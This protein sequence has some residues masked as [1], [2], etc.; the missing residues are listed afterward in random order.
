M[1]LK[2][3]TRDGVE[4]NVRYSLPYYCGSEGLLTVEWRSTGAS[5][6]IPRIDRKRYGPLQIVMQ[7]ST[8]DRRSTTDTS[9]GA[10]MQGRW[11]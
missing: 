2:H 8:D 7:V 3:F 9:V 11:M 10:P 5:R 6:F 1:K 4:H